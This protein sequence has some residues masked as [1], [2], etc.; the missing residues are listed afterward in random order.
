MFVWKESMQLTAVTTNLHERR[1][2]FINRSAKAWQNYVDFQALLPGIKLST[3]QMQVVLQEEDQMIINGSAGSGKSLT[4]LYKLLKV[5]EQETES[6]R[7]LYCSF[8]TTLIEDA[9]KRRDQSQRYHELKDKHTVH[10]RT[11]HNVAAE[12]LKNIGKSNITFSHINLNKLTSN[13]DLIIRRTI[14]LVHTYIE[15]KDYKQLP[16]E[17]HLYKTHMGAFLKDEILWMKANGFISEE[18]YLE[19]ER[20]GRGSNPR[21]TK[22]QRKTVFKLYG[23]YHEML[24]KQFNDHL[25]LED[26]ALLLLKHME[27]I[28]ERWKYDY[29]FVDEVQDL[30]AM[31]LKALVKLVR[32]SII[33]SGDPKQRIYKRSPF[34][35]KDLGLFIEGKKTRN[36]RVNYRSTKQIMKLASSIKFL[37]EENDRQDTLKFVRDGDKPVISYFTTSKKEAAF[38]VKQINE[39]QKTDPSASIAII[40]RHDDSSNAI[41]ECQVNAML[42]QNFRVIMTK[43][44]GK[45]FEMD[46]AKKPVFYTDA[47]SV[48][49]LEFD[50]VFIIHFDRDHYPNRKKLEELDR[51]ANDRSSSSYQIDENAIINDEKKILY[52]AMTRAKKKI[53]LTYHAEKPLKICQSI[54]DFY[55][56]DYVAKGFTAK[57]YSNKEE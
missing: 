56:N 47:Y 38:I 36:L 3:E 19:C 32:K 53:W 40:H 37:D 18:K 55:L 45:K 16:S 24:K 27:E 12:M 29:I 41:R 26:Y 42:N 9:R 30:Q 8:N 11:F 50:Y 31:Q 51:L 57:T 15:T 25:D 23:M 44:Y 20:A 34:S 21:L 35:Y 1:M 28:P 52:V 54:R 33:A 39:I 22:E 7:I 14:A 43:E 46:S 48:K 2:Q 17:Q 4:L 5:M 49:G 13:E 10:L 6:K